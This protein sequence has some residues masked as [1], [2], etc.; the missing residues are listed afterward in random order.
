M[1]PQVT[2]IST[3]TA[4]VPRYK[5]ASRG[6]GYAGVWTA[7]PSRYAA[8][9]TC[10][11][12]LDNLLNYLHEPDISTLPKTGHFYFALTTYCLDHRLPGRK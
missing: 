4:S 12:P 7:A 6:G 11:H 5:N 2:H 1:K 3:A 9:R 10:P 8:L